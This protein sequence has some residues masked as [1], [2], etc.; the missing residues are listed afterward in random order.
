MEKRMVALVEK[1]KDD[2]QVDWERRNG[3]MCLVTRRSIKENEQICEA[4]ALLFSS[5]RKVHKLLEK[6]ANT[7]LLESSVFIKVQ[8]VLREG[9]DG[10]M[11]IFAV[12]L[13]VARYLRDPRDVGRTYSNCIVVANPHAGPND[14]FLVLKAK[15]HKRLWR[16][17]GD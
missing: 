14:G 4:R 9:G 12:L 3:K 10:P 13:G 7:A 17:R 2:F 11:D 1:D 8:G 6:G 5:A 16:D 15:S